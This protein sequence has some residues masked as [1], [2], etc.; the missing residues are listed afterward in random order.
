MVQQGEDE[1]SR[2]NRDALRWPSNLDS[3]KQI[4]NNLSSEGQGEDPP[5]EEMVSDH[6]HVLLPR[7]SDCR[8]DRP[9][10]AAE[11]IPSKEDV[12]SCS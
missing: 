3:A 4:Q 8:E 10:R 6:V 2:E 5:Q 11:G 9:L 7:L 1:T 12:L